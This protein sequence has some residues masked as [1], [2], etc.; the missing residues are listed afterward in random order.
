[1]RRVFGEPYRHDGIMVI[2]V[3]SIAAGAGGGS[4]NDAQRGEG[5][6]GANGAYVIRDGR[7][8]WRPA[9]DVNRA[10]A[11]TTAALFSLLVSAGGA[12]RLGPRRGVRGVRRA[13]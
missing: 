12:Q 3:A 8:S 4:G 5:E 9:F 13:K 1:V 7:I 6:G 10:L 2:P 11:W